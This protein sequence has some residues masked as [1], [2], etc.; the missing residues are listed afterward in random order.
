[1]VLDKFEVLKNISFSSKQEKKSSKDRF[2]NHLSVKYHKQS[3]FFG[4]TVLVFEVVYVV[5][6]GERGD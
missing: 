4:C 5:G 3:N 1:M 6:G 2:K